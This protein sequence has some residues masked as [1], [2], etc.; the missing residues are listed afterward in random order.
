MRFAA[1]CLHAGLL[2]I[3]LFAFGASDALAEEKIDLELVLAVDISLSMDQDE[4]RLQR[5]GYI[6]A[7][8]HPDVIAAIKSGGYGRI[9]VSYVEWA[10]VD[11][12]RVIAPW[13]F[14]DSAVT[15]NTFASKLEA[16][17]INSARRTSISGGLLFASELFE[18]NGYEGVRRV[19]D[20][21]GDGPNNMGAA[22]HE[23][24]DLLVSKGI[25]INGLP[26]T[27]KAN[28]PAGFYDVRMLEFYYE[29]CV[30]GGFGSFLVA[31]NDRKEFAVAIRRK[32][33]L[34][35]AGAQPRI[36]PARA[37]VKPPREKMDCLIGEKIWDMG[38]D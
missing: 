25:V 8:R 17:E 28:D 21:S 23:T 29:D 36:I 24:R 32:L 37:E 9:A 1:R 16:Q 22:V 19:I 4:Q 31:V 33:I 12:H 5:K 10:G 20:V 6:S 27:L 13:T 38:W 35:I 30:I 7:I 2:G 18:N 3:L 11:Y 26:V 14:I 15:A 34:E